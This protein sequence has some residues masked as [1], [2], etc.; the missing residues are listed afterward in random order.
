MPVKKNIFIIVTFVFLMA[1]SYI[2]SAQNKKELRWAEK[3]KQRLDINWEVELLIKQHVGNVKVDSTYVNMDEH[4]VEI[5]FNKAFSYLPFR[6]PFV[7]KIKDEIKDNIKCRFRKFNMFVFADNKP[8]ESLIPN[9]YR[10]N[11]LFDSLRF[12]KSAVKMKPFVTCVNKPFFSCGLSGLNIALWGSHGRYYDITNDRWKWQR[13][14]LFGSVEDLLPTGFVLNYVTPML[15]NA[16]AYVMMPRE[17]DTQTNEVIVDNDWSSG[18][19][20]FFMNL[21]KDLIIEKQPGFAWKDT[22]FDGD[23][24]FLAG[25]CLSVNNVLK[26]DI[27][28]EYIPDIPE[29][30]YYA[31]YVSFATGNVG[32]GKVKYEVLHSGGVTTFIV[33]QSIGGGTWIYL[34][35]F[36]FNKGINSGSGIVKLSSIGDS[37]VLSADAVRFGGGM[38]NV[39]RRVNEE[40]SWTLSG[41]PRYMEG[42][43]YNLQYSGFPAETV[44]SLQHYSN[45]YKD[46]Y[47]SRGEWINYLSGQCGDGTSVKGLNIPISLALAFHTDAGITQNDSVVGTLAIFSTERHD[48]VFPDGR[49]KMIN[50]DFADILQTQLVNDLNTE[51]G[52]IWQRRGLW[53]KQYSEAWRPKVPI[54]LLEL[55]SHQNLADMKRALDP[56]FQFVVGRAIYKSFLKHQAFQDGRDAIVQPLPVSHLAITRVEGKRILLS[57]QSV[58]DPLESLAEASYFMVYK[59][60]GDDGFDNGIRV[61]DKHLDLELDLYNQMYSFKVTAVNDGGESFPSEILSVGLVDSISKPVLVVNGF[62]RVCAPHTFLNGN[63]GGVAWWDDE[64]VVYKKSIINTGNQYNFD[65][66]SKWVDDD[67]PGWGASYA[68]MEGLNMP[69]NSFD[70]V[71][72]HGQAIMSNGFSFVSMSDEAFEISSSNKDYSVIDWIAGEEKTTS[73][74]KSENTKEFSVYS[75]EMIKQLTC[76]LDSG[77]NLFLSGAYVGTDLKNSMH[78]SL[79]I[80][81]AADKLHFKLQT[82]HASKQGNIDVIDSGMPIFSSPLFFNTTNNAKIYKVESPDAIKSV[83]EGNDVLRYSENGTTSAVAFDGYYKTIVMGF[84][85]ETV[86]DDARRNKLMGEILSFFNK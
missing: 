49:S 26:G 37:A 3:I 84:P 73:S 74:L 63:I 85:F 43:R 33:N 42:A 54:V 23:N 34:G 20:R 22:L 58:S 27:V 56:R 18:K 75:S 55:L 32:G 79:A 67:A 52:S 62:D 78:D 17:R 8:I 64:G 25:T 60:I 30:G 59:R 31:V 9:Y 46:D 16:G 4:S 69:G 41:V 48:G 7:L 51:V 77:G 13:P 80:R 12:S 29:D 19:S 14:R 82:N 86:V 15:E 24:P 28:V 81:F 71:F 65:C 57:W 39:A 76:F 5:Y 70:N 21:S 66:N 61:D 11:F 35:T 44:Y 50:R 2:V 68:D 47:L 1:L 45:D 36:K 6:E 40:Q 72:V 53:D 10:K 83:T 38:G